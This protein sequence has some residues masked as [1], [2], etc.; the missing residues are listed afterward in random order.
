MDY[1]RL[2][3]PAWWPYRKR[4]LYTTRRRLTPKEVVV[5]RR[6]RCEN[7]S[8]PVKGPQL[9]TGNPTHLAMRSPQ[10]RCLVVQQLLVNGTADYVNQ[11]LTLLGLQFEQKRSQDTVP[12]NNE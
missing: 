11:H 4:E 9:K 10:F 8:R 6:R 2:I 3:T 7:K 12:C 5:Y 1:T